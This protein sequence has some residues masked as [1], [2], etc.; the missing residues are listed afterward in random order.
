MVKSAAY[1]KALAE[2][3]LDPLTQHRPVETDNDRAA[4]SVILRTNQSKNK[5]FQS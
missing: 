4:S 5:S 3:T 2:E 1:K